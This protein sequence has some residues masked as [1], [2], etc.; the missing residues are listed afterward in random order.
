MKNKL[1]FI[2]CVILYGSASFAGFL[3]ILPNIQITTSDN[4]PGF[5]QVTGT[6]ENQGD[7]NVTDLYNRADRVIDKFQKPNDKITIDE[8]DFYLLYSP[9]NAYYIR[10]VN[11]Y[12]VKAPPSAWKKD[13]VEG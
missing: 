10:W 6:I 9:E 2:S 1:V 11:K 7:E 4:K 12:D 3:R 8:D 5:V 13:P